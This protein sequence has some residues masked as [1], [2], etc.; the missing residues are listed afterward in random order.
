MT[1]ITELDNFRPADNTGVAV[2]T[3]SMLQCAI[4]CADNLACESLSYHSVQGNCLLNHF[5]FGKDSPGL[6]G[7]DGWKT[8]SQ[9]RG[10]MTDC[11]A[12]LQ[13][14][15]TQS[16][17]YN[18]SVTGTDTTSV[19]CD[20]DTD[21]GGWTVFQRRIDGATD[22]FRGWAEYRDGFG[23]VNHEF[24]LGLE[25]LHAFTSAGDT[26]L[27]VDMEDFA[28]NTAYAQYNKFAIGDAA[29]NYRLNISGFSGNAGNSLDRHNGYIFRTHDN[30]TTGC[31]VLY[32]SAWWYENCHESN[33]NG[34][35]LSGNTSIYAKG[36]TWET[37]KG[38]YYSLKNTKMMIRSLT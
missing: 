13:T 12:L 1:Q 22:F 33:L 5:L 6:S 32:Q 37:W 17:V 28:N 2:S 16:G 3:K 8:Y 10:L 4:E 21:N 26:E 31:S 11:L 36:I 38:Y 7:E 9:A 29:T 20:M 18:V 19:W 25:N 35:Y 34:L 27:R 30:D 15:T 24:W 14:G 23:N